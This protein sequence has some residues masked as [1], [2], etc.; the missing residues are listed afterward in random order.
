MNP[1][2]AYRRYSRSLY[3]ERRTLIHSGETV[4]LTFLEWHSAGCVKQ[5][6]Y[7]SVATGALGNLR[8]KELIYLILNHLDRAKLKGIMDTPVDQPFWPGNYEAFKIG[9]DETW[10]C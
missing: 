6:M 5:L 4:P 1:E 7:I 3:S 8:G 9:S 10:K 2:V